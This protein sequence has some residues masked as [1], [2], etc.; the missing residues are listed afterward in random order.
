MTCGIS[1]FLLVLKEMINIYSVFNYG[2]IIAWKEFHSFFSSFKC[3][4]FVNVRQHIL[5]KGLS[6]KEMFNIINFQMGE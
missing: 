2:A 3:F 4:T 1:K 6:V 5:L